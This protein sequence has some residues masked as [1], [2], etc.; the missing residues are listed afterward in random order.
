MMFA[1]A[2]KAI[3]FTK[4]LIEENNVHIIFRLH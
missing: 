2:R 1:L 3:V 4:V